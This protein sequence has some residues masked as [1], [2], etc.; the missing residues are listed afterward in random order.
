M[1]HRLFEANRLNHG[2]D[3]LPKPLPGMERNHQDKPNQLAQ[4]SQSKPADKEC[5]WFGFNPLGNAQNIISHARQHC[6]RCKINATKSTVQINSP[7]CLVDEESTIESSSFKQETTKKS[8]AALI[9]LEKQS[10]LKTPLS[11]TLDPPSL[12]EEAEGQSIPLGII[13]SPP[14]RDTRINEVDQQYVNADIGSTYEQEQSSIDSY[15]STSLFYFTAESSLSSLVDYDEEAKV[16]ASEAQ[17]MQALANL[18]DDFKDMDSICDALIDCSLSLD[19]SFNERCFWNDKSF[20]STSMAS[21]EE[22]APSL[23]RWGK[24]GNTDIRGAPALSDVSTTELKLSVPYKYRP[25]ESYFQWRG[26]PTKKVPNCHSFG[27]QQ[28]ENATVLTKT[29]VTSIIHRTGKR[30]QARGN[31]FPIYLFQSLQRNIKHNNPPWYKWQSRVTKICIRFR[32]QGLKVV[33]TAIKTIE[34]LR[35]CIYPRRDV[36]KWE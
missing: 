25:I 24:K 35:R 22:P 9:S 2:D 36:I 4:P 21:K 27:E 29:L 34:L 13:P 10:K 17:I 20:S 18:M 30:S 3:F 16:K 31:M 19:V 8:M 26:T 28:R 5:D 7:S 12:I 1:S 15:S 23:G 6:D 32:S 11:V 14:M 33:G